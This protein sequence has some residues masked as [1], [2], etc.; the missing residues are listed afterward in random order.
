M[1]HD[2]TALGS[3]IPRDRKQAFARALARFMVKIL[4]LN[5]SGLMATE[6]AQAINP[7][8]RVD[9]PNG[10]FV[11]RSGHGRLAW[12]ARTFFTEE[13]DTIEW[14]DALQSTDVFWDVGANVGLYSIYAA[15]F[16]KCKV[17]AFEP[18]SQNYAILIDN[19]SMNDLNEGF[20]ATC[21]ALNEAER[22]GKLTVPYITKGGAYNLFRSPDEQAQDVPQSVYAAQAFWA[23]DRVSQLTFGSSIDDLV[24]GH[25]FTPPSHIKIDVDGIEYMIIKGAKRTLESPQLK[26]VLIELN[27]KSEFDEE[28]PGILESFGFRLARKRSVWDSKPDKTRQFEMPSYNA[29]FVRDNPKR[30][31]V[32]S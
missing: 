16:R 12:R 4:G 11:C 23:K 15:K 21:I 5:D 20:N 1:E 10:P 28:V 32:A 27:E 13:P 26:S 8:F 3:D 29:I 9:T 19:M 6:I 18:E 30:D 25:G 17:Y 2:S 7:I 14:L 24:F 31:E 22:F